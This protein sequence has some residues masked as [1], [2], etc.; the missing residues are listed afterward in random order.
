METGQRKRSPQW[1]PYLYAVLLFA[2]N[3]AIV[4]R[5]FSTEFTQHLS[6]NEGSFIAISRFLVDRWPD[7]R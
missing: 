2:V 5:F 7:V 1:L 4:R 3:F 6:S